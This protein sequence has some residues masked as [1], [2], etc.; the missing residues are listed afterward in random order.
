MQTKSYHRDD[1]SVFNK[2]L[3][4]KFCP[5]DDRGASKKILLEMVQK[6]NQKEIKFKG[7]DIDKKEEQGKINVLEYGYK[8]SSD[9]KFEF[10]QDVFENKSKIVLIPKNIYELEDKIELPYP[11]NHKAKLYLNFLSDTFERLKIKSVNVVRETHDT[12]NIEL[13]AK[14][15][16]QM[17]QRIFYDARMLLNKTQIKGDRNII[18]LVFAQNVFL[19]NVILYYQNM[20]SSF[21][22][23]KKMTKK[24]LKA[25]LYDSMGMN[26]MMEPV[27]EYGHVPKKKEENIDIVFKPIKWNGQI[28]TLI[29]YHYDYMNE[30]LTNK[31]PYMETSI[32]NMTEFIHRSFIDKNGKPINKNTI[33]MCLQEYRDDKRPKGKKRIDIS[34][35]VLMED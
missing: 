10:V 5:T 34:K 24:S 31:K 7:L 18:F 33:R 13:Y 9:V 28:N 29:A 17:A 32:E 11:P 21:Y 14:K 3:R 35:Y 30:C 4:K 15:N 22:N 26:I 23:E 6:I 19:I 8:E 1:V 12:K 27:A 16:I 25:E 20:F 2:I